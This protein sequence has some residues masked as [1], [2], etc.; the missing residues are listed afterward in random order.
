MRVGMPRTPYLMGVSGFSSM[1]SLATVTLPVIS[2]A[3]SSRAGAIILQ[4]PHHSAQKST[5]TGPGARSTSA[6]NELS[7]IFVVFI[8]FSQGVISVAPMREIRGLA[9]AAS[10]C[11]PIEQRRAY[12]HE[13]RAVR[14]QESAAHP[15]PGVVLGDRPPMC[16]ELPQIRRQF[17]VVARRPAPQGIL[18]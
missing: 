16:D 2:A 5:R 7:V 3:I 13:M 10:R 14:P 9:K 1:L 6:S 4:G 8:E 15:A 18:T 17:P 11:P 12:R